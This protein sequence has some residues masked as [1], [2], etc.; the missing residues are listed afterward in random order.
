M[1][2]VGFSLMLQ[3][4]VPRSPVQAKGLLLSCIA[5]ENPCIFFEPKILY[6]AAGKPSLV[7]FIV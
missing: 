6:R 3:V 4:V 1:G 2:T 7:K 5:D